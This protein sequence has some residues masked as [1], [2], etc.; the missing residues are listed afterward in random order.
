LTDLDSVVR[1]VAEAT[2]DATGARFVV[3][4]RPDEHGR[5][6]RI[7][8]TAGFT[9]EEAERVR[10]I[11]VTGSRFGLVADVLAGRAVVHTS[12]IPI[13]A[14]PPQLVQAFGL[15]AVAAAPIVINDRTWGLIGLGARP[16]DSFLADADAQLITGLAT[17]VTNAIARAE[18]VSA[19]ARSAN[20]LEAR[21]AE[22][23]MQLTQAVRELRIANDAK[24]EFLANVSHELRTPLTAILGFSDVLVKGLDGPLNA[25][26]YEDV[27]SIN[28]SSRRLLDLIDDLIDISRVEAGR[29]ELVIVPLDLTGALREA[30]EE[31][32]PLAGEKG[33]ALSL[34]RSSL[35][36]TIRADPARIHE[37]LLNLLSNAVKF[38][39]AGGTVRVIAEA[40]E[41]ATSDEPTVR[42]DVIDS[43]MGVAPSDRE[44]IFEKFQRVAG[45]AYPGTGLGLA[46]A[47]AFATLHGGSLTVESTLGIG[48][49]FSLR[50][51][52]AGPN[53]ADPATAEGVD[54]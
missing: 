33:I 40:E 5:R 38:T 52:I 42:I 20:T 1:V 11:P 50:L 35:P 12:P 3:V 4:M 53:A 36:R 9:A 48:S 23:T 26:Q 54:R 14:F 30:V 8:A 16:G 31:I 32:R 34:E 39:P 7:V 2:H 49:R 10:Q 27:R 41:P 37:I 22:R 29:I 47:R 46:I 44:R 21:V 24:N 13:E 18:A 6:V 19:L 51:P 25:E 45:P 43:G 15:S 17:V 28:Q